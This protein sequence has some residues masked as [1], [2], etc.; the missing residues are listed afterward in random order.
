[1]KKPARKEIK[2]IVLVVAGTFL[3]CLS[4]EMFI[5]PFDILSGGVAGIAVAVQPLTRMSPTLIANILTLVLLEVGSLTLGREFSLKTFLSSLCYPVF[6]SLLAR[7]VPIPE[8]DPVL[9]SFYAGLLGGIGV[10]LVMRTGASTGGMDVP[11][12][13]VHK[14]T[15]IPVSTL[16]LITDGLTV[17]LG[18]FT[19]GLS[20]VLIGLVSVFATSWAINRV[21]SYGEGT[22]S[23]SVQIISDHWKEIS[24][25]IS[26]ELERG[27]TIFNAKGTYQGDDR[28]VLLCVVSHQQY[29]KLLE[30]INQYD[31][32]AFV[33]TTDATDMHGEGFTYP[34]F[35]L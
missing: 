28:V 27:S 34:S 10:G 12:L 14:F 15:D 26:D 23:K 7:V 30:I 1:M 5:L 24:Q 8:I 16:V 9:A 21:L 32:K 31:K 6:N 22:V 29:S 13:I 33:I 18:W 11:P 2:D 19:Y 17:L 35:H 25:A 3:L 4:V 20:A